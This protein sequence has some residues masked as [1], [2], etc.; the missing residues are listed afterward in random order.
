VP[1]VELPAPTSWIPEKEIPPDQL[2][3][4]AGT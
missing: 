3:E 4:P 2:H 1:A